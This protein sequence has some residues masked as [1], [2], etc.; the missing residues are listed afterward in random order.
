MPYLIRVPRSIPTRDSTV[1]SS[2]ASGAT[3]SA[4]PECSTAPMRADC[5]KKLIHAS[6]ILLLGPAAEHEVLEYV[7]YSLTRGGERDCD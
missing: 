6:S 5:M 7:S 3:V 4:W 2:D 1:G